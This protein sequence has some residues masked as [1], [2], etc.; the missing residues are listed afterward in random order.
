MLFSYLKEQKAFTAFLSTLMVVGSISGVL[1][2]KNASAATEAFQN[3]QFKL[4]D[5]RA[6][7]LATT[8]ISF[9]VGTSMFDTEG[10]A[11]TT[12]VLGSQTASTT[13]KFTM[14]SAV[15]T[16]IVAA[17]IDTSAGF[18]VVANEAACAGVTVPNIVSAKPSAYVSS[19]VAGNG[20]T[21][22]FEVDVTMCK[23]QVINQGQTPVPSITLKNAKQILLPNA[24]TYLAEILSV[25]ADGLGNIYDTKTQYV[26]TT[27]QVMTANVDPTLSFTVTGINAGLTDGLENTTATTTATAVM[28][29]TLASSTGAQIAAQTL[30]MSTNANAGASIAMQAT[31]PFE[32][33][34]GAVVDGLNDGTIVKSDIAWAMPTLSVTN[35]ITWGQIAARSSNLGLGAN[36]AFT[37]VGNYSG[38]PFG[39]HKFGDAGYAA[40]APITLFSAIR[41]VSATT[42][43]AVYKAQVTDLQ[44]AA[45]DYKTEVIYTVT[46][47]F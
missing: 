22:P 46:P 15:G 29:G 32:S 35:D 10:V 13:L 23:T 38:L 11:S 33:A 16:G 21:V 39:I 20:T 2:A 1:I 19:V 31:T 36:T 37:A 8:T 41:P 7:H 3:V 45:T 9:T 43:N 40:P 34:N 17:D 30:T 5:A 24:G 47:S 25:P 4:N 44:E 27:N 14:A 6:N 18:T 28:F 12:M 26:V 42:T